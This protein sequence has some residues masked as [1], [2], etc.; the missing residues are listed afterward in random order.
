V[1]GFPAIGKERAV[2]LRDVQGAPFVQGSQVSNELGDRFALVA[3]EVIE[4][5]EEV[6]IREGVGGGESVH[7][8]HE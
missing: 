8:L 7:R 2:A 1:E 3:G 4:A 5:R 6:P